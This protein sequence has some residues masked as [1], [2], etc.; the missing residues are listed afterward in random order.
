MTS[1]DCLPHGPCAPPNQ[2]LSSLAPHSLVRADGQRHVLTDAGLRCLARRDRADMGPVVGRWS[3]RKRRRRNAKAS[4]YAGTALRAIA[5]QME[6][7]DAIDGFAAERCQ[8]YLPAC[9]LTRWSTTVIL[10]ACATVTLAAQSS[11]YLSFVTVV[12]VAFVPVQYGFGN[13]ARRTPI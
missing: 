6:H 12:V 11:V 2:V 1:G 5:S 3:A 10:A 8:L 13:L 4:V 9:C 7:H